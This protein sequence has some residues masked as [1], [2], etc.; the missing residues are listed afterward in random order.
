MGERRTAVRKK[1]VVHTVAT[2]SLQAL[3]IFVLG[4]T[5]VS[6]SW[7]RC[8][9]MNKL[10]GGVSSKSTSGRAPSLDHCH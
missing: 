6:E 8:K 7:S 1:R 3:D 2:L 4:G 5:V 9:A 10:T